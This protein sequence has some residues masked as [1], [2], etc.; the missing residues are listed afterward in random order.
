MAIQRRITVG[1]GEAAAD[2]VVA[3]GDGAVRSRAGGS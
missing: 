1:M 2:R 3:S